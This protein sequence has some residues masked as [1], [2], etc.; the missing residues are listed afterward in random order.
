MARPSYKVEHLELG[1]R[2]QEGWS[3]LDEEVWADASDQDPPA[4]WV[5]RPSSDG[6]PGEHA[7]R[8]HRPGVQSEATQYTSWGGPYPFIVVPAERWG[9]RGLD[10]RPI[11]GGGVQRPVDQHAH[12]GRKKPAR[13]FDNIWFCMQILT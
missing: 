3:E 12:A 13:G 8:A 9:H 4:L 7:E 10:G 6:N 2:E 5:T 1:H 11:D